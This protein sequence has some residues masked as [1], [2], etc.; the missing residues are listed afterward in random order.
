MFFFNF[1]QI[2][3]FFSIFEPILNKI[4]TIHK[5]NEYNFSKLTGR[6]FQKAIYFYFLRFDFGETLIQTW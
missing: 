1:D 3:D 4:K 6:A 2:F 5:V